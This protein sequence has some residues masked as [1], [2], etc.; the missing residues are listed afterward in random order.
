MRIEKRARPP[1]FRS[2]RLFALLFLLIG[3]AS[4]GVPPEL[5]AA[6][7][8]FRGDP[9]RGWSY[10]LTTASGSESTVERCNGAR[11]EFDRWSLQAKD[12][13]V[14]TPAE[15]RAYGEARS[16][17]SRTGTAPLLAEQLDLTTVEAVSEADGRATYRCRLRPGESRDKTAAYLRATIVVHRPTGTIESIELGNI[18]EF[19]PAIGVKIVSMKTRM[20]YSLPD[21]VTPSLPREVATAV[22]GRAFLFKSLDGDMTVTYSDYV[23]PAA[24]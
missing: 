22:R 24:K 21:G 17:R 1:I 12:G 19:S 3:T 10:T 23:P 7:Q 6:L 14:P 2:V 13:R 11:P 16:W 9:P 5:E 15:I 20:T 4:A 18:S 8:S